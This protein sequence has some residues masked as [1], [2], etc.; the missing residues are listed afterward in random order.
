MHPV[1]EIHIPASDGPVERLVLPVATIGIGVRGRILSAEICLYLDDP[2][3]RA[4]ST[5]ARD[6]PRTQ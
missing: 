3:D 6:Q 2:S 1:G 4:N 5:Q